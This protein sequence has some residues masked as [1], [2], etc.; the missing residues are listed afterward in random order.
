MNSLILRWLLNTLALAL[1][2]LFIPGITIAGIVPALLAA[3]VLGI[4]NA[5][6]RPIIFVLTLPINLLTLGLFTLVINGL[7]L[8]M[9]SGL[10]RGFEVSGFG[11]AFLGALLLSLFSTLFSWFVRDEG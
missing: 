5:V 3:L 8:W 11:A 7:M 2:A 6:I 9:V 1:A 10:V 4:I